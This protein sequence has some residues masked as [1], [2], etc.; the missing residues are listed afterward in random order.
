M[1][2][3]ALLITVLCSTTLAAQT[4][5]HRLTPGAV[6]PLSKMQICA[7]K[8]GLDRRH[9]TP[10]K[11]A[12]VIAA[13]GSPTVVARGKGPCCEVDHLVPR[14]LG[15]ADT[16]ANLWPQSWALATLKDTEENAWHRDVCAGRIGLAVAQRHFK[17]WGK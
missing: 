12:Q 1:V 5:N 15:G 11:R 8:W 13:Y 7:T 10:A 16:V 9:V 17:S 4:L 14:E 2:A 3:R 6:R